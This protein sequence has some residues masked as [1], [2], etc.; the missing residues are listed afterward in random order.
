MAASRRLWSRQC[1]KSLNLAFG[2]GEHFCL[3][4]Q[5]ARLEG[6]VFFEELLGAFGTVELA[7]DPVR[8]RSNLNNALKRLP[9]RLE[10]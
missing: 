8:L 7:G 10:A 6:R 3:G 5:L 9:V 4:A 2:W 1:A